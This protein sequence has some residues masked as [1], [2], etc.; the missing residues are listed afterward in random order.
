MLGNVTRYSPVPNNREV[1][2]KG[3]GVGVRRIIY[4]SINGDGEGGPNKRGGV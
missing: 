2:I 3:V 1:L 4:I